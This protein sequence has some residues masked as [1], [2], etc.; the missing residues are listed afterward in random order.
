MQPDDGSMEPERACDELRRVGAKRYRLRISYRKRGDLRFLSHLDFVRTI[1]RALRRSDLPIAFSE[2]FNPRIR[3]SF[4]GAL[5]TGVESDA[6]QFDVWLNAPANER[7]AVDRLRGLLP[8]G[9]EILDARPAMGGFEA[10]LMV[11]YELRSGVGIPLSPALWAALEQA[12][13]G[14]WRG[15]ARVLQANSQQLLIA[16]KV[17]GGGTSPLKKLVAVLETAQPEAAPLVVLKLP[18]QP[19]DLQLEWP[20]D[21]TEQFR[22][23]FN[24]PPERRA[25]LSQQQP[26]RQ[27]PGGANPATEGNASS[28]VVQRLRATAKPGAGTE[29]SA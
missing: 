5:S 16:W 10:P 28:E 25:A 19:C 11:R 6:E 17:F 20:K 2:G 1:E 8:D 12:E 24:G 26:R 23:F 22:R 14:D 7:E 3:L 13:N 27:F 15:Y 29:R 18:S 9:L 21:D 4:P